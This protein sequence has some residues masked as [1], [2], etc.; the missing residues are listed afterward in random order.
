[1]NQYGIQSIHDRTLSIHEHHTVNEESNYDDL[2][3]QSETIQ[4]AFGQYTAQISHTGRRSHV[5]WID[6]HHKKTSR[7]PKTV[8][9]QF[10]DAQK[11]CKKLAHQ[12]DGIV[13]K[14]RRRL[15]L[16]Y[17]QKERW[18]T[19][20]WQA[21]FMGHPTYRQMCKRL[22][23][24]INGTTAIWHKDTM[25]DV[26]GNPVDMQGHI[27]L[28]HP[29][30]SDLQH[31]IHW[32][33]QLKA[34]RITQPFNQAYRE[35]FG[36]DESPSGLDTYNQAINCIIIDN[37]GPLGNYSSKKFLP[38]QR[39]G[40]TWHLP[41]WNIS[42][43]LN[44]NG[45]M[46][47]I[48]K[49]KTR[50]S[51]WA[52]DD[53]QFYNSDFNAMQHFLS[54]QNPTSALN[55]PVLICSEIMLDIERFIESQRVGNRSK[56]PD[57]YNTWTLWKERNHNANGELNSIANTRKNILHDILPTLSIASQCSITGRH[58]VIDGTMDTYFI[59]L[60]TSHVYLGVDQESLPIR[61]NLSI[62][63]KVQKQVWLPFENDHMLWSILH[64]AF[65][66]AD[67]HK[68]NNRYIRTH[69][70]RESGPSN[71]AI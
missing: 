62:F 35:I 13:N 67:D 11:Q 54:R 59:H 8:K 21:H 42:A 70:K 4:I 46:G 32:Q 12:L 44:C 40:H 24:D 65:M 71:P 43:C 53:M 34:S 36:V 17:M 60:G 69:A 33:D 20:H 45:L 31:V 6:P 63:T 9:S 15:E 29:M 26:E 19:D 28:W 22:I 30:Y 61:P 47:P 49:K 39:N 7:I 58:L 66:L 3:L 57:V 14:Q 23:W 64:K 1:M 16:S 56:I 68:I 2:N 5:V 37:K 50:D 51:Y 41:A 25:R 48:D 55:V 18:K 38:N 52:I 10:P 27:R